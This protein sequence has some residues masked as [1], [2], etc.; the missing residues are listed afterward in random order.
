MTL[1]GLTALE[2]LRRQLRAIDQSLTGKR[3]TRVNHNC[4]QQEARLIPFA[5]GYGD[6]DSQIYYLSDDGLSRLYLDDQGKV[7]AASVSTERV[8]WLLEYESGLRLQLE[9]AAKAVREAVAAE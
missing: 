7:H 3:D 6:G 5:Y 1:D 4:T 2:N 8:K 9:R